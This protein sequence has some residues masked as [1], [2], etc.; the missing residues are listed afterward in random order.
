MKDFWHVVR[1]FSPEQ[2]RKL[3]EFVTAS[4]RVPFDGL[5]GI[6][7]IIQKNGADDE[8]GVSLRSVVYIIMLTV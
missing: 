1:S 6:D 5:G 8:V 3:L 7:F 2:L 4:D